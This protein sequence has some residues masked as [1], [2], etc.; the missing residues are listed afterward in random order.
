MMKVMKMMM[1]KM[2]KVM[3][4]IRID[5]E[6]YED[7]DDDDD[8][9]ERVSINTTFLI[10]IIGQETSHSTLLCI[11][12]I[13]MDRSMIMIMIM[14]MIQGWMMMIMQRWIEDQQMDGWMNERT[15]I[16]AMITISISS[17]YIQ[18]YIYI[19]YSTR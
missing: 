16:D 18:A 10:Y 7:D 3:M 6:S 14:M 8:D 4:M 19:Y 2:M 11:L 9:M 17:T 13:S 5:D 1:M 12:I 15:V